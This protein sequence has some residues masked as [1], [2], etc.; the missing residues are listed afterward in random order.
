[1]YLLSAIVLVLVGACR[2]NSEPERLRRFALAHEAAEQKS[3]LAAQASRSKA[4]EDNSGD[5]QEEKK[6]QDTIPKITH[7][8]IVQT[9][10]GAF[11]LGLYG[12]DAPRTVENFVKLSERKFYRGILVHRVAK[13]FVLQMGDPKTKDKR[14]RDE[15]GNGGES[16][17]GEPFETE[18]QPQAISVQRGYRRGTLA[19]ANRGVE[20]NTS[21]FFVCLRDIPEMPRT[22][23]IFGE[24]M[25]GWETLD[26]IH[27]Q[28]IIPILNKNDGR[29]VKAIVI[30]NINI[31]KVY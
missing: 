4:D 14:K 12:K 16:A 23:T 24:V 28:K 29:P 1:M 7:R 25:N 13:D 18:M 10:E 11:T 31:R 2:P 15:W 17:F 3:S 27:A 26:S 30:T 6:V 5:V 8:A 20:T 19:M 9:S 22:Y 21:Q